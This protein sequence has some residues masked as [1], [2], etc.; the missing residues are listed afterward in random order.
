LEFGLLIMTCRLERISII[1]LDITIKTGDIRLSQFLKL[2]N[3][4]GSGTEAKFFIQE[5]EVSVNSEAEIRRGRK[6]KNGDIVAF[7]N[8]QYRVVSQ[9]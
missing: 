5:G 2:A 3:A 8:E 9:K 6:L 7:Q 4:V 1:T